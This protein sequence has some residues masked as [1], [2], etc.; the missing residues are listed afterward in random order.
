MEFLRIYLILP[1]YHG[2]VNPLNC[3]LLHKPFCKAILALHPEVLE[4][5][6]NWWLDA[7]PHYF[8]R[9]VRVHK[10]VVLHYLKQP[11]PNKVI[12]TNTYFII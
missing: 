7:P 9:L 12:L 1:L 8:E 5:V 10:S 2:F 4:V 11:K 6:S 3:N